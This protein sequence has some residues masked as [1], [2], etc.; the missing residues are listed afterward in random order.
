MSFGPHW[1]DAVILLTFLEGLWLWRRH[2]G[3]ARG[4]APR[5]F[6]LNWISGLCLMLAL[7]GAV[8]GWGMAWVLGW[9]AAS[10]L[11]HALDL[12]QRWS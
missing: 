12:R 2:R 8:V 4:V 11:S 7:R 9:L 10:G 1:I 3:G 6:G 5:D